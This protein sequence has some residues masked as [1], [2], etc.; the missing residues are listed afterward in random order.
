[1]IDYSRVE[2]A[3]GYLAETD[4]SY[5]GLKQEMLRAEYRAKQTK[6]L[7][8]LHSQL[9]TVADRQAGRLETRPRRTCRVRETCCC[10]S[11]TPHSLARSTL[12]RTVR[13]QCCTASY[14]LATSRLRCS[15]AVIVSLL[16]SGSLV[17]CYACLAASPLL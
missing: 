6:S 15:S 10:P 16:M 5:A 8:F 11:R 17:T 13:C 3:L 1:M 4:E 9:K 12:G 7:M 14:C 2:K